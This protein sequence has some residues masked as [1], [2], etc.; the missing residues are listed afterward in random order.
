VFEATLPVVKSPMV[1][2]LDGVMAGVT[3]VAEH[4]CL[5]SQNTAGKLPGSV[6]F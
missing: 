5:L 3:P 1:R 2:V 6:V 4:L